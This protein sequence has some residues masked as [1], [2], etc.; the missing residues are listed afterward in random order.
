MKTYKFIII[1]IWHPIPRDAGSVLDTWNARKIPD[2]AGGFITGL[3]EEGFELGAVVVIEGF[4]GIEPKDPVAGGVAE[5]L[6]ARRGK[7]VNPGEVKDAGAQGG[8]D[9]LGAVSGAGIDDNHLDDE[10]GGGA[11]GS[12]YSRLGIL[13]DKTEGNTTMHRVPHSQRDEPRQR[14]GQ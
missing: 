6:I 10:V 7:A 12:G 3:V 13:R 4:I 11:Q 2:V 5:R 1:R 14:L 9:F 8:G